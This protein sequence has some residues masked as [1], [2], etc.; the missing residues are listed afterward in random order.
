M[1]TN[2]Q[3]DKK[4]VD[5]LQST[6][7]LFFGPSENTGGT[8]Y[9]RRAINGRLQEVLVDAEEAAAFEARCAAETQARLEHERKLDELMQALN[10]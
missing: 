6:F 1:T 3:S 9:A 2:S 5:T 8:G 10:E 7:D 4:P